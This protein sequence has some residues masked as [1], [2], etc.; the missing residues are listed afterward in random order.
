MKWF[1]SGLT[2]E[3]LNKEYKRLAKQYHPDMAAQSGKDTTEI[4]KEI[5]SEYDDYFMNIS[6]KASG[7]NSWA[8]AESAYKKAKTE[9]KIMLVF[10]RHDKTNPGKFFGFTK[11]GKVISDD[12]ETW[13]NCR[14]GFVVCEVERLYEKVYGPLQFFEDSI[15]ISQTARRMAIKVTT[16]TWEELYIAVKSSAFSDSTDISVENVDSGIKEHDDFYMSNTVYSKIHHSIYGDL[17]ISQEKYEGRIYNY[18]SRMYCY[19]K[20][21]NIVMRCLVNFR[22]EDYV[23]LE[24]TGYLNLGYEIYQGCSRNEFFKTHDIENLSKFHF[25]LDMQPIKRSYD[26]F[27]WIEN[28]MIAFLARKGILTFYSSSRNFKL[29]YGVF[30][31]KMLDKYVHLLSYDDAEDCQ[32]FLDEL[33]NEVE[34]RAKAMMRKGKIRIIV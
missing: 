7:F 31:E 29:R 5:N 19:K 17:I 30:N 12:S 15:T 24:S 16:P 10:L 25:A 27:Y 2:K 33:R 8:D 13:K 11:Y 1:K 9:R 32:D 4:M 34:D 22:K 6:A 26:N 14:P 28:P 18:S 23:V 20:A 21:G 3:E